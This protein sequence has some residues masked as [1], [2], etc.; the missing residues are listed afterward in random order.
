[1][2]IKFL[3][4]HNT[5]VYGQTGAGKTQFILRVIRERLIEPFPENIFYMYSVEQDFMKEH[6][7]IT[8]IKGLDFSQLDTSKPSMLVIDDLLLKLNK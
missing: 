5:I 1:M 2:P 4:N 8:F 3:A 6:A 7:E